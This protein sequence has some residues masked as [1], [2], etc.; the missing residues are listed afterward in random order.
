M[1]TATRLMTA[2][3]FLQLP[4]I[5]ASLEL[6]RGEVRTTVRPGARHGKIA[7][8]VTWLLGQTVMPARLGEI[9]P[10]DTGFLISRNPDTVRAPDGAFIRRE[11]QHE[12]VNPEKYI[13]IAPDLAVEVDSPNDRPG[14]IAEKIAEWL[15]FGVRLL[16]S[17]QPKKRTVTVH[18]SGTAPLVLGDTDTLTGGDVLPAFRCRV[19]E[20]FE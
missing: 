5:E 9:Y 14:D 3:E 2:D 7:W 13:P 16:W 1:A 10:S 20:I 8:R 11:R 15:A 12:I 4:Q 6:I 19:S 17:I 18:Q